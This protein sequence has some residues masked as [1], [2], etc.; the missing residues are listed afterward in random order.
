[1]LVCCTRCGNEQ[2]MQIVETKRAISRGEKH[3]DDLGQA[4]ESLY[5]I[6]K[7]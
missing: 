6:G 2:M 4:C 1:M 3:T 5:Y 7:G